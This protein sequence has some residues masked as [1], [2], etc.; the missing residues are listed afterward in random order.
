MK[1][2]RSRFL[3]AVAISTVLLVLWLYRDPLWR[4]LSDETVLHDWLASLGPFGPLAIIALQIVQIVFAPIPGQVIGMAAG[5]MYGFWGGM[6]LTFIGGTLGAVCAMLA[7]RHVGRPLVAKF[8]EGAIIAYVRR[9]DHV[10]SPMVWACVFAL[11]IGDPICFAAGLTR[12]PLHLLIV[13]AMIG[14]MPFQ[15]MS[16]FF[17]AETHT[18]GAWSW[19]IGG[20]I[21]VVGSVVFYLY[22]DRIKAGTLALARRSEHPNPD[23]A[24]HAPTPVS[25]TAHDR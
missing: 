19:V 13:G 7:G 17:G 23:V 20:V 11:P 14:R 6:A 15:V 2:T 24:D 21:G 4:L 12:V 9:F 3:S 16:T 8:A 22:A 1:V 18:L 10:R 25:A 5:Y